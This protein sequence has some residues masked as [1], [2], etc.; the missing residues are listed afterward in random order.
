MFGW[1]RRRSRAVFLD[2]GPL[3]DGD[4]ELVPPDP[5]FIPDVLTACH[6][7]LTIEQAPETARVTKDGLTRF[8]NH[9]P[10][11]RHDGDLVRGSPSYHFW[12]K[13]TGGPV[14]IAG[15]IGF[16]I[17]KSP[18]LISVVGHLGYNVYPPARGHHLA[19]RSCRLLFPLARRHGFAS[20]WITCNPD[21]IASRRTCERLGGVLIDIVPVPP[22]NELY[23][24]GDREKCRYRIDL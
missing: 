8:L 4:L 15:G 11:G 24:R 14:V 18:D 3:I 12:M 7:P 5:R 13:L 20:V 22:D 16:R 19:E 23:D 10:A 21:N 17:G 6:H 2:P 1:F 9:A